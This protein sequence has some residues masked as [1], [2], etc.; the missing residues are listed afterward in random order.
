MAVVKRKTR[1][2]IIDSSQH[3]DLDI[4]EM[5][6]TSINIDEDE[7]LDNTYK[8]VVQALIEEGG[9]SDSPETDAQDEGG[10]RI[11]INT[12]TDI[13]LPSVTE[14]R[15]EELSSDISIQSSERT[16]EYPVSNS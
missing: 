10:L 5:K 12:M 6:V 2:K 7:A 11:E 3:Y 9:D 14:S 1:K 8:P 13:G 4:E 16:Q 15:F